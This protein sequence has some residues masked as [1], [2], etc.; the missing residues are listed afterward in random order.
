MNKFILIIVA[1]L[2]IY[3][4]ACTLL[5]FFQEKLIFFPNKLAS[6][7][8]FSF[9]HIEDIN[10]DVGNGVSI[11]T[12]LFTSKEKKGVVFFLHGNAGAIDGWGQG[13]HT[14]VDNGYDVL[15][16]DYRGYGKSS[17]RI[18]S[19]RQLISDAQV[20]YE[21][22]KTRYPENNIIVSGTS[23]GSGI[24]AIMAA[25][26]HPKGLVLSSPY[27][28]L[29]SLVKEKVPIAP[30]FIIKYPLETCKYLAM[31]KCPILIFHGD[32]DEV[33][34]VKHA[35]DLKNKYPNVQLNILEGFTHND[36]PNSDV[37]RIKMKEFL[38]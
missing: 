22:L 30:G 21:F 19:E 17:G 16:M 5:Y 27:F 7:Y 37:Y 10:H 12:V 33:I 18:E 4:A 25:L 9:Q 15:Y 34:P 3:A 8:T 2:V 28:S 1:C 13:A 38:Q 6:D 20:V 35:L 26:N 23:I 24:A 32:H 36:L 14:Y 29:K 11:N 31:V